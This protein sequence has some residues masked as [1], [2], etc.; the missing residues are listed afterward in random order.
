MNPPTGVA[1]ARAAVA[2][3]AVILAVAA[4][5]AVLGRLPL[6]GGSPNLVIVFVLAVGLTAGTP[7]G[8]SVGFAAGLL[9]DALSDHPLGLL[10]C[11]FALA[12][13]VAGLLETD[14][15][16]SVLWPLLVVGVGAAGTF[17]LYLGLLA[18]LNRP[19]ADGIGDLPTTVLYDV[20]LTPFVIPVV[21][22]VTRRL[23]ADPRR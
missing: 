8:M 5:T 13:F 6:P 21:A 2:A 19:P 18:I 7:A 1:P 4:Q 23:D 17:L 22:A 14:A 15:E 16:R 10:A 12:G 3:V 11:C 20:M 9:T